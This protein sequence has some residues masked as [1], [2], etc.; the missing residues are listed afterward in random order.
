MPFNK[1]VH[2]RKMFQICSNRKEPTPEISCSNRIT[3]HLLKG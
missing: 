3:K 1:R 2:Q